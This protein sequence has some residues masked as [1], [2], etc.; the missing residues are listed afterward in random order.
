MG[1]AGKTM[2]IIPEPWHSI[3]E[4][5]CQLLTTSAHLPLL[6]LLTAKLVIQW[7]VLWNLLEIALQSSL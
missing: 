3:E 4:K 7:F 2:S 5:V 1:N 6:A